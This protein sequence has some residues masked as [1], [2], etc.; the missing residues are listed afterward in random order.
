MSACEMHGLTYMID[1]H[2]RQSDKFGDIERD[3]FEDTYATVQHAL[4]SFPRPNAV[5][6]KSAPYYRQHCWRLAALVYFNTCIRQCEPTSPLVRC[7]V[8]ELA[9]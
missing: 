9:P 5:I 6:E 2:A 7:F 3:F 1:F 4:I 8:S